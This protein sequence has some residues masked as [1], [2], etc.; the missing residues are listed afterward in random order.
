M[1]GGAAVCRAVMLVSHLLRSSRHLLQAGGSWLYAT[2]ARKGFLGKKNIFQKLSFGHFHL[3]GQMTSG[4]GK[5]N[6][7][8]LACIS[9]SVLLGREQTPTSISKREIILSQGITKED[10]LGRSHGFPIDQPLEGNIAQIHHIKP[11]PKNTPK[12][13]GGL[14]ASRGND[15]HWRHVEKAWEF[16]LWTCLTTSSDVRNREELGKRSWPFFSFLWVSVPLSCLKCKRRL[17]ENVHLTGLGGWDHKER[18]EAVEEQL[19]RQMGCG[20]DERMFA[21]QES[22]RF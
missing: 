1:P 5:Q 19:D 4:L 13:D 7:K 6:Y 3:E 21:D 16:Y 14:Q 18:K 9:H 2:R 11:K 22:E 15:F 12:E 17:C 8:N 20:R 10:F